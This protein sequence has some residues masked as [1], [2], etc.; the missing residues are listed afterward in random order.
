MTERLEELYH[1]MH[2]QLKLDELMQCV[3]LEVI[4][5]GQTNSRFIQRS[6]LGFELTTELQN[7]DSRSTEI[8][9]QNCGNSFMPTGGAGDEKES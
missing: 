8:D 9:S 4:C 5:N 1:A 3:A 2:E 6:K 7:Y